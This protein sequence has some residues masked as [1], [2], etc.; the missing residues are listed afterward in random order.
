MLTHPFLMT[1]NVKA[2]VAG[3]FGVLLT[4]QNMNQTEETRRKWTMVLLVGV[5]N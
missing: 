5:V 1:L 2:L 3:S 4:T